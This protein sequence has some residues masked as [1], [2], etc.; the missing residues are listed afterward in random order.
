MYEEVEE[1]D[2][3]SLFHKFCSS[4]TIHGTYYWMESKSVAGKLFWMTMVVMGVLMA[5]FIIRSSFVG[6]QD[7]PV[8]T[9]VMQKSIEEIPFPAITICP[10]DETR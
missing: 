3:G 6:W 5:G 9:S 1:E 8:I 2:L 7:N 4:S 10:T